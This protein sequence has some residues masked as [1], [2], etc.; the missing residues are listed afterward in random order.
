MANNFIKYKGYNVGKSLFEKNQE[1]LIQNI[2]EKSKKNNCNLI[3]PEDVIVAKNHESVGQLKRLDKINDND[4][5]LDIGEKSIQK[6]YKII[7]KSKT[8]LWN[9]PAGYFELKEFSIGSNRIAKKI[10]ENTKN[11]SLRSIAENKK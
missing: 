3:L 5:I 4:L 9:G 1:T 6:I 2:I 8:V 10:Y 11:K 7:D